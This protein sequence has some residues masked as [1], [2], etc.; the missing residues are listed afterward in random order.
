MTNFKL[1][2]PRNSWDMNYH[3]IDTNTMTEYLIDIDDAIDEAEGTGFNAR[4]YLE[5]LLGH[6]ETEYIKEIS[7]TQKPASGYDLT[8]EEIMNR[9]N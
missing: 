7:W 3:F 2:N 1:I 9:A 5:Y 6:G 8:I 4:D